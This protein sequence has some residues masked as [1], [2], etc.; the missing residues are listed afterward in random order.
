MLNFREIR[1]YKTI[2][3]IELRV[4]FPSEQ[5]K[6]RSWRQELQSSRYLVRIPVNH[7][8]SQQHSRVTSRHDQKQ[9]ITFD[10][11]FFLYRIGNTYPERGLCLSIRV[12]TLTAEKNQTP[13]KEN[14]G[15]LYRSSFSDHFAF[16]CI[17][18]KRGTDYRQSS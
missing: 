3:T 14:S 8:S 11:I 12:L 2:F 1:G 5:Q 17:E 16:L 18:K 7:L 4:A 6:G 10:V 9:V 15:T 13:P